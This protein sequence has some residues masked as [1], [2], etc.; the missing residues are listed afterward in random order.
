M[1]LRII[2]VC[3]KCGIRSESPDLPASALAE[4]TALELNACMGDGKEPGSHPC[5][6]CQGIEMPPALAAAERRAVAE[7]KS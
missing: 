7:R 2:H 4:L 1:S 5:A 3:P 6:T